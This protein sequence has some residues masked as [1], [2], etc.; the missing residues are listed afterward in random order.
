MHKC[1]SINEVTSLRGLHLAHRLLTRINCVPEDSWTYWRQS[2]V[3]NENS[4]DNWASYRSSLTVSGPQ[5]KHW[6]I[7]PFEKLHKLRSVCYPLLQKQRF[8]KQQRRGG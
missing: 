7:R 8:Q 1:L 5:Q 6:A 4:K 3:K 2:S